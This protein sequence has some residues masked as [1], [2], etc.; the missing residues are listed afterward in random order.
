MAGGAKKKPGPKPK[1]LDIVCP[2]PKCKHSDLTMRL[3]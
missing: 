2:N 1:Y 3:R